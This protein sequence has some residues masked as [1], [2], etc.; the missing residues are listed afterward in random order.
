MK[1]RRRRNSY[2]QFIFIDMSWYLRKKREYS[3]LD[4]TIFD[5]RINM[6]QKDRL[7]NNTKYL[8]SLKIKMEYKKKIWRPFKQFNQNSLR[9]LKT[10]T[11]S[12]NLIL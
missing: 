3:V 8:F 12:S 9:I 4:W 1:R 2:V 7:E 11:I 10:I 5:K 6:K